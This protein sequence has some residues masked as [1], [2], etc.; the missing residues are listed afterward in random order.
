MTANPSIPAKPAAPAAARLIARAKNPDATLRAGAFARPA[1]EFVS[2]CRIE[3]GFADATLSAYSADLRDLQAWME[4]KNLR[5]WSDLNLDTIADHLRFLDR[6]RHLSASSI[7]R[8][9]ATIRVFGRF[10]GA[11]GFTPADPAELPRFREIA[12][13]VGEPVDRDGGLAV[14]VVERT[15]ALVTVSAALAEAGLEP[16]DLTVRRPTLDEA[17]LQ[18]TAATTTIGEVTR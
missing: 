14:P 2:Y 3:C 9:V 15:R 6:E 18:L 1:R 5:D 13:R 8:H 11:R 7:A 17:F 4:S 10:L 12:A 16:L